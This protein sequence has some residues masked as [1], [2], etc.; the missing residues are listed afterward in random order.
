MIKVAGEIRQ[1]Y[2][3]ALV[4][5]LSICLNLWGNSWGTPDKW[6]PDEVVDEATALVKNKSL[7]LHFFAYGGLPYY[8]VAATA[9]LPVGVYNLTVDRKPA[10]DS[11]AAIAQWRDRKNSNLKI[12]ART[13]SA[14]MGTLLVYFTYLIGDILFGTWPGVL[15][16]AFLAVCP[17]FVEIAHFSTVD[18]AGNFWFWLSCLCSLKI[19]KD[20]KRRWYLWAAFTAG[21]ATGVK[22]DRLLA[23]LPMVVA[24]F[25]RQDRLGPGL[26]RI[27]G[28]GLL[29]PIGYIVANP[30]LLFAPF[31]FLDGMTRELYFN[32]LRGS[33]ITSYVT[34]VEDMQAGMG[35]LL[36]AA[37]FAS[38][39]FLLYE[40]ARGRH[41][42]ETG[43][44]LS[45]VIPYYLVFGSR[46]SLPWYNPLFYPALAIIAAYGC[47]SLL[48]T[49]RLR[50]TIF[51]GMAAAIIVAAI[52]VFS[53]AKSVAVDLQFTHDARY[54]AARWIGKNIPP[55]SVI[56]VGRRGP[57]LP[58]DNYHLVQRSNTP[59]EFY[60][61]FRTWSSDLD[62]YRPYQRV[63][64]SIRRFEKATRDSF[65]LRPREPYQ[66]WFDRA[67]SYRSL[68]DN[69]NNER[70]VADY[71]V[72][73]DYLDFALVK[74]CQAPN[75]GYRLLTRVHYEAPFHLSS[76]FPFVNPT[77]YVFKRQ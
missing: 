28:Y 54:L 58:A 53:L 39:A 2:V 75:S 64:E 40:F 10:E 42:R 50:S 23:V 22:A 13:V 25:L 26:R 38:L 73:V 46:L 19:W 18:M 68:G 49:L 55:G 70:I 71:R 34:L 63:R 59:S 6:H 60:D 48:Q 45:I 37:S 56:E 11:G 20:G 29:V 4:M 7:N 61:E 32:I 41:R 9:V 16:A 1:S 69:S 74:D 76:A 66:A 44:L 62:N 67:L 12:A 52:G 24:Q 14:V 35:L 77:V 36:F 31:E 43:W 57:Q 17:Y 30:T 27:L 72:L 5:L 15:A 65:G 33:G 3:L 21:L 47:V 51:A 8:V